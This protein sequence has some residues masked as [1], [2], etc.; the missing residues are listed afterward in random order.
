MQPLAYFAVRSL[1]AWLQYVERADRA[2]VSN[3]LVL[4][5]TGAAHSW[6]VVYSLFIAIHTRAMRYDG[7]HEGYTEHLPFFVSWTETLSVGAMGVWWVAGFIIAAIRIV[8]DDAGGLPMESGDV[9]GNVFSKLA[10]SKSVHN[11]L[12][13]VQALSCVALFLSIV[14]LCIAMGLMAGSITACELCLVFVSMGF[15]MPHAIVASRRLQQAADK[16]ADDIRRPGA[17][18]FAAEAAAREAATLG[19]QLCVILALADSPGHAY[20]WQKLIYLAA[21]MNYLVAV[22]ACGK[23][24]PKSPDAA[25]P[26][27]EG[28]FFA[29]IILDAVA[30]LSLVLCYPYLNTWHLWA[31]IAMLAGLF[32]AVYYKNWRELLVDFVDPLFVVRSDADRAVPNAQRQKLRQFSWIAT[33]VCCA[34]ALWDIV[35][36]PV[37]DTF[38]SDAV[39]LPTDIWDES[40]MMLLRWKPSVETRTDETLLSVASTALGVSTESLQKQAR[41]DDHRLF[42]FKTNET[43][44]ERKTMQSWKTS[45]QTADGPLAQTA[46][47]AFPGTL[48]VSICLRLHLVDALGKKQEEKKPEDKNEGDEQKAK[49]HS[50]QT[51]ELSQQLVTIAGESTDAQAAYRAAC[52]WWTEQFAGDGKSE[53]DSKPAEP[54]EAKT[55]D[56]VEQ[57]EVT[58]E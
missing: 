54:E 31:L 49:W 41:Y 46:D 21:A 33:L 17:A 37:Q 56:E 25:L 30:A 8:D 16:K 47:G 12:V 23:S 55:G 2:F 40:S 36:H 7:Y 48:N 50:E 57:A 43:A 35:L 18:F 15:A 34:V 4:V 10:Q 45:L 22:A 5:A 32:V 11:I 1:L 53:A 19:P 3:A 39:Q 58:V 13:A 26:P 42:I 27:E 24:P 14:I 38:D 9:D 6:A 52:T 20:M 29:S 44:T 51:K 28:E